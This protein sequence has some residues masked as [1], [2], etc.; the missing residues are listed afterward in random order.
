[1]ACR[2]WYS[3]LMLLGIDASRVVAMNGTGVEVYSFAIIHHLLE[4]IRTNSHS[5]F[6][7]VHLYTP[8]PLPEGFLGG[9]YP[10]VEEHV[11]PF[12]R[13]WTHIRLSAAML[14]EPPDAL[15]IPSHVLPIVHPKRSVVTIHDV[16]FMEFPQAYGRFQ[17]MYLKFSTWLAVREATQIVVPSQAVADDLVKYF[18]CSKEK[19]SV[20]HHGF[21]P[22]ASPRTHA[23]DHSMNHQAANSL[24]QNFNIGLDDPYIFY[25]GRLE[26]KKN[27]RRLIEAFI[28]FRKTHP[29]WK[30][31]LAG[32][33]GFGFEEI[34]KVVEAHDAWQYVIMP[35]FVTDEER[36]A[37]YDHCQFSAFVSLSEGFGFPILESMS[38]GKD[39]LMSDIPVMH[40]IAT[41]GVFVDPMNVEDIT[42]GMLKLAEKS[43]ES[44]PV[45]QSALK[46]ITAKYSWE[47]AAEKT[48]QVLSDVAKTS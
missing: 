30:L 12:P 24:L 19:I 8:R 6:D 5:A 47:V 15:F 18:S 9:R 2:S 14:Q 45:H 44:T 37:L 10:F 22:N 43:S 3:R 17:R 28:L 23:A 41:Q 48:L 32:S 46:K 40:E 27:L 42:K 29:S 21:E 33:R 31:I 11:I 7:R 25:V 26:E 35:G 4:K 1:M 16:A 20:I 34:F 38:Y 39:V 13:V 36:D